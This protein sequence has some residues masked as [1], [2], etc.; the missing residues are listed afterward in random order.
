MTITVK[1]CGDLLC[2]RGATFSKDLTHRYSLSLTWDSRLPVWVFIM[3]NPSTADEMANDPTVT[4]C[5]KRARAGG[6]GCVIIVNLYSLRAT[7]PAVLN[8]VPR[9][10]RIGG[11]ENEDA[12]VEA[13]N[14]A[15]LSS[16]RVV[17]AWG[18]SGPKDGRGKEVLRMLSDVSLWVLRLSQDGTPWHPLYVPNAET[19]KSWDVARQQMIRESL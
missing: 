14:R 16:G 13:V 4:R 2:R 11:L 3:L 12:I 9:A 1:T 18:G 7:D 19:L 8:T 15:C 17:C 6:A 10:E 5:E